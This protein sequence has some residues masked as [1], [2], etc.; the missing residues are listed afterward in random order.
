MKYKFISVDL[1]RDFTDEKGVGYKKRPS[2]DFVKSELSPFFVEKNISINEIVSDYRAPRLGDRGDLCYPGEWG[3]ESIVSE[4]AKNPDI[5]VKCMN[6]PIW[7][8]ENIGVPDSKPGIPYQDPK[9]FNSWLER[10]IGKPQ[11]EI[12]IVLFGLTVD[13]CVLCTA[14][15]LNFRGYNVYILEEATDTYSGGLE[16]KKIILNNPPLTNWAKKIS[17]EEIKDSVGKE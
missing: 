2:V 6:S 13:C 15:E 4:E 10:T 7:T 8:R 12:G 5:Y 1:Q 17:W 9:R 11:D 14:Q 16:E 3:Y